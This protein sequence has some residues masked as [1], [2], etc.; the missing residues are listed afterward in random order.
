[1][2][3]QINPIVN[4]FK[5]EWA[6]LGKRKKIFIL[7][8]SFFIIA[9]AIDLMTPLVIGTI[10]NKIQ[11]QITSDTELR[12]SFSSSTTQLADIHRHTTTVIL[13]SSPCTVG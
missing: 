9:G 11:D 13:S 3:K 6:H 8:T 2:T 7:Y 5:T 12:S 4:T 1:M 10:F